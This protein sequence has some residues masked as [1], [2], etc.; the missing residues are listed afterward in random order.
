MLTADRPWKLSVDTLSGAERREL[1]GW[2]RHADAFA[3]FL[4]GE[5]RKQSKAQLL[6]GT[7]RVS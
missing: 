7:S 1:T 4:T 5:S 6:I 2:V 3:A